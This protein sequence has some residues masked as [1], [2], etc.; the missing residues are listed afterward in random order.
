MVRLLN[1]YNLAQ[2]FPQLQGCHYIKRLNNLNGTADGTSSD[3]NAD[4]VK[5][6][7]KI[8]KWMTNRFRKV[9]EIFDE[10]SEQGWNKQDTLKN[11]SHSVND[12]SE[13]ARSLEIPI[14]KVKEYKDAFKGDKISALDIILPPFPYLEEEDRLTFNR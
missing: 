1:N 5:L 12:L 11:M 7:A 14:P 10:Y 6:Q 3:D 8:D 13:D 4:P 2:F 9:Q